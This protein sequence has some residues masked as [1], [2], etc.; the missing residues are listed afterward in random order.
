MYICH[1]VTIECARM[2]FVFD[3]QNIEHYSTEVPV[4]GPTLKSFQASFDCVL[5]VLMHFLDFMSGVF[6]ISCA[7]FWT[8]FD[9]SQNAS[10][11]CLRWRLQRAPLII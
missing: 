6:L 11:F 3:T 5:D 10:I 4:N 8:D 1:I 2:L 9:E 7:V